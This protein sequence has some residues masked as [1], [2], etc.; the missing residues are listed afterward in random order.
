MQF[1]K[2][3]EAIGKIDSAAMYYEQAGDLDDAI[4]QLLKT[5][6]GAQ[7]AVR[8][9]RKSRSAAAAAMLVAHCLQGGDWG[10]ACEFYVMQGKLDD[11]WQVAVT[12]GVMETFALHLPSDTS[13]T[14]HARV[15]LHF[16]NIH[17]HSQAAEQ[18]RLATQLVE[19][20]SE[21]VAHAEQ[22]RRT[23]FIPSL[24]ASRT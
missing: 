13:P 7:K 20:V 4:K 22:V 15:A 19:C 24:R 6:K 12:H 9:A 18:Y 16:K 5:P 17:Q 1:A 11:A 10:G 23:T 3:Q 2:S 21:L 14:M 8:L